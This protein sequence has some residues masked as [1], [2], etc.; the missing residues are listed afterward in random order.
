MNKILLVGISVLFL[1]GCTL[2]DDAKI[3]AEEIWTVTFID[4]TKEVPQE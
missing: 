2:L 3:K 1:G 4:E